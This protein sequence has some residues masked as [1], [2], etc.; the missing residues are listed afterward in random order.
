MIACLIGACGADERRPLDLEEATRAGAPDS[1]LVPPAAHSAGTVTVGGEVGKIRNIRD[2]RYGVHDDR[3]RFVFEFSGEGE[4]PPRYQIQ[5]VKNVEPFPAREDGTP[6]VGANWGEARIEIL[7]TDVYGRD[8]FSAMEHPLPWTLKTNPVAT[9]F[10][11]LP[12]FDDAVSGYV[13]GIKTTAPYDV[14]VY[15]DPVRL[16]I[17]VLVE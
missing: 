9:K 11:I 6:V 14:K 3:V 15:K 17:D 8:Y 13:V 10:G 12:V 4:D 16:I 5:E 7:L 2:I 1:P